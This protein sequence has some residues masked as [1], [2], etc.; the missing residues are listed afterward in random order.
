MANTVQQKHGIVQN[1]IYSGH[2]GKMVSIPASYSEGLGRIT[3][4]IWDILCLVPVTFLSPSKQMLDST[5]K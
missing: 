2:R 5:L 1:N 3:A 4:Q